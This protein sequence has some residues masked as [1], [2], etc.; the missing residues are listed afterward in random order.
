VSG[1][2]TTKKENISSGKFSYITTRN[3]F[4]GWEGSSNMSTEKGNVITIDSATNGASFYQ[5]KDFVASDH[6]EKI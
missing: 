4:N 1:T 2:K 6:V 3:T 5:D